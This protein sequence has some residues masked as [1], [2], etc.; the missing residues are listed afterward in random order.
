MSRSVFA[1]Q[2]HSPYEFGIPVYS[3]VF[4]LRKE[5]DRGDI[6]GKFQIRTPAERV[7][8]D[9]EYNVVRI[10]EL[11]VDGLLNG[12]IGYFLWRL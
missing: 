3:N 12:E 10:W 8:L 1:L 2:C 11:C 6:T 9:F 5:V 7:C 4:L